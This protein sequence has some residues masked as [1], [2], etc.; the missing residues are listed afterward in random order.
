MRWRWRVASVGGLY[1]AISLMLPALLL[2]CS[3]TW[4]MA[5]QSYEALDQG[6]TARRSQSPLTYHYFIGAPAG[7]VQDEEIGLSFNTRVRP[8]VGT[9]GSVTVLA[10]SSAMYF[11]AVMEGFEGLNEPNIRSGASA[12]LKADYLPGS[13]IARQMI[14][15]MRTGYH[16]VS[17]DSAALLGGSAAADG[18]RLADASQQAAGSATAGKKAASPST[19]YTGMHDMPNLFDGT[20]LEQIRACYDTSGLHWVLLPGCGNATARV[21]RRNL[22]ASSTGAEHERAEPFAAV[23]ASTQSDFARFD[24]SAYVEERKRA[25]QL[26]SQDDGLVDTAAAGGRRLTGS[27]A[28]PLLLFAPAQSPVLVPVDRFSEGR[29]VP[30]ANCSLESLYTSAPSC[31]QHTAGP[32]ETVFLRIRLPPRVGAVL[33][34][35]ASPRQ[36]SAALDAAY[37]V[38][39][40][41]SMRVGDA[42]AADAVLQGSI[43]ECTPPAFASCCADVDRLPSS[44][45]NSGSTVGSAASYRV[46]NCWYRARSYFVS[47]QGGNAD[48]SPVQ[49]DLFLVGSQA[50]TLLCPVYS[51]RSAA[52]SRCVPVCSRRVHRDTAVCSL[53]PVMPA[54]VWPA[55]QLL[56]RLRHWRA[57]AR[58]L[59][60]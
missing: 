43:R 8:V 27:L 26:A 6:M 55:L 38:M 49:F 45:A 17:V 53:S 35:V 47:V 50:D 51:W 48:G 16:G 56:G 34:I 33:S 25:S 52:W 4:R 9:P 60:P 41:E 19:P 57:N 22:V 10:G 28:D 5:A 59:L 18:R 39:Y 15:G 7:A 54:C 46:A 21:T 14:I 24:A 37:T 3:A 31:G 13:T 1:R 40:G 32:Q 58:C 11:P 36:L 20:S 2:H 12:A 29:W 23:A 30:V 44:D 42:R